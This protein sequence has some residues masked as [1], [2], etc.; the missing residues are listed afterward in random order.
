MGMGESQAQQQ[1]EASNRCRKHDQLDVAGKALCT[2]SGY[3]HSGYLKFGVQ[4]HLLCCT[5]THCF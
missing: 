5:V 4:P 2:W 1:H 3:C